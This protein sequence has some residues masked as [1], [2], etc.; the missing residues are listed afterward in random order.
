MTFC[1]FT[2]IY[3]QYHCEAWTSKFPFWHMLH[4]VT[5][6]NVILF[7]SKLS[8]L[9]LFS[10]LQELSLL[11]FL[12]S[13]NLRAFK[14]DQVTIPSL[15]TQFHYNTHTLHYI[16]HIDQMLTQSTKLQIRITQSLIPLINKGELLQPWQRKSIAL[17]SGPCLRGFILPLSSPILHKSKHYNNSNLR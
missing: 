9:S 4:K 1:H 15:P 10:D 3:K 16:F 6:S 8:H 17:R 7:I 11:K 2:Y 14:H 12:F 5:T 13:C